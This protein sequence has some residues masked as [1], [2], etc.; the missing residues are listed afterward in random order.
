[1]DLAYKWFEKQSET[2]F[3]ASE[4]ITYTDEDYKVLNEQREWCQKN[5]LFYTPV[6][7][8]NNRPTPSDYDASFLE[9]I[10]DA[11]DTEEGDD[12]EE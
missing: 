5:E 11:F 3:L 6:L 10:I 12:E 1:M 8:V 2:A 7:I 4:Q 9:D